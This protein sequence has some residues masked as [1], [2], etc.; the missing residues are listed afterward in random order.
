M[1]RYLDRFASR[2]ALKIAYGA[3]VVRV[4][5]DEDGLFRLE[6]GEGAAYRART[7]VVAT[8]VTKP[9]VPRPTDPGGWPVALR[10]AARAESARDGGSRC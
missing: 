1:V 3:R 4:S 9:Y 6:T 8:G 7:L 10:L 5:R 2:Y